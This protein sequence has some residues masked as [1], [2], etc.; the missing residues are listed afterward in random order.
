[1]SAYARHAAAALD[2]VASLEAARRDRD[3]A[4]ALLALAQSLAVVSTRHDVACRVAAAV[5]AVVLCEQAGVWLWDDVEGC[6]RLEVGFPVSNVSLSSTGFSAATKGQGWASS[7]AIRWR[8]SS[9]A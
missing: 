3:M 1:M 5:P 9:T 7:L 2:A 8:S 4:Q 6:L